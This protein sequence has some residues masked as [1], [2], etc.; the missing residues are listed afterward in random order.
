MGGGEVMGT[1]AEKQGEGREESG[2][3][4]EGDP[5]RALTSR[6]RLPR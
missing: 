6:P 5:A 3:R 2:K 1:Q 4:R